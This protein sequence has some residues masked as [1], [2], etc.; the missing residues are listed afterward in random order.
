MPPLSPEG[1]SWMD[2]NSVLAAVDQV[3]PASCFH[4]RSTTARVALKTPLA[5]VVRG[6][7]RFQNKDRPIN[8]YVGGCCAVTSAERGALRREESTMSRSDSYV[9]V[10]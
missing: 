2:S 1:P 6:T 9:G 7:P 8:R 4:I 10:E 5:A 3:I